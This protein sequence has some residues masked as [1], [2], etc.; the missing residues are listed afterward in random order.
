MNK[1][2][3]ITPLTVTTLPFKKSGQRLPQYFNFDRQL[4]SFSFHF[5]ILSYSYSFVEIQEQIKIIILIY[6]T[7][8]QNFTLIF[9]S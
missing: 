3:K 6:K 7:N 1:Q 5:K 4:Y 8:I 2:G 9:I